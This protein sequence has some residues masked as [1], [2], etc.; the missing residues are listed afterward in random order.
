MVMIPGYRPRKKDANGFRLTTISVTK[1]VA[2]RPDAGSRF[3]SNESGCSVKAAGSEGDPEPG[4]R[5]FL[6]RR[7]LCVTR[8]VDEGP[9][10]SF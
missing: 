3:S 6:C 10:T 8:T 2:A 7:K 5:R 1:C 9:S 4:Q